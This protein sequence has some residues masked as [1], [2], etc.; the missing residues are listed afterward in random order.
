MGYLWAS[1]KVRRTGPMV[2]YGV[3]FGN[4]IDPSRDRRISRTFSLPQNTFLST[5]LPRNVARIWK[6]STTERVVSPL[7]SKERRL[8]SEYAPT[9]LH[10]ANVQP[11][12]KAF[13]ETPTP[14]PKHVSSNL[15]E[16]P[17]WPQ[18][19]IGPHLK[20]VLDL[21]GDGAIQ[22][23]QY[24]FEHHRFNSLGI[25]PAEEQDGDSEREIS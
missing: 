12:A 8:L 3:L 7:S 24:T 25:A 21:L 1:N 11:S 6:M 5:F 10:L 16:D 14:P 22:P 15:A 13:L 4:R 9:L 19:A 17:V 23:A 2:Y 20:H 18:A